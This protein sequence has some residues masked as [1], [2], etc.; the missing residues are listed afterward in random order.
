[1]GLTPKYGYICSIFRSRSNQCII[2]GFLYMW[3]VWEDHTTFDKQEDNTVDV[4]YPPLPHFDGLV[5]YQSAPTKK[6][7]CVSHFFRD[8][9]RIGGW[10]NSEDREEVLKIGRSPLPVLHARKRNAIMGWQGILGLL[11]RTLQKNKPIWFATVWKKLKEHLLM[12]AR[13]NG[14]IHY[15]WT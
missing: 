3:L 13:R 14:C 7:K 4:D 12:N 5:S 15:L 9:H 6:E 11:E 10:I 2:E 1:M 8:A